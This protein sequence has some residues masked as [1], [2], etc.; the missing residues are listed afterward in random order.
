MPDPYMDLRRLKA[1]GYCLIAR[2]A[3]DAVCSPELL[4]RTADQCGAYIVYDPTGDKDLLLV[5]DDAA[6]LVRQANDDG[7]ISDRDEN[8]ASSL[9]W[10]RK[11]NL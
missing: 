9:R 1:N 11:A 4:A 5:G 8:R 6:A 7:L 10:G 3:F 2:D